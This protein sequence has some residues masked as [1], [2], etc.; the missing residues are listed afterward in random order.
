MV[1]PETSLKDL[2]GEQFGP[3]RLV[4]RLG[5][6]GMAET[7]EAIRSG[8]GGF[9]QRVCLK[10]V[11]PFFHQD[12]N[13]IELFHREAKLAARLRHSNIVGVIDFGEVNGRSYMALELVDGCDLRTLLDAQDRRRLP[14]EQ[15]AL[16]GLDLASALEHAHNPVSGEA[17]RESDSHARGIVH[18]D[19]SP[20]NVLIS[21]HGDGCSPSKISKIVA[22]SPT[23]VEAQEIETGQ[24]S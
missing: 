9:E 11:L 16:I 19:I 21:R 15:V 18:R 12:E 14:P 1:S 24:W 4:R 5:I 20:S 8:P 23:E 3:Y 17:A 13:F 22:G 6:G 2:I 7:F 10:L